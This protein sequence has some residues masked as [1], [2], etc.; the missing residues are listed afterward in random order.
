MNSEG[1]LPL[2]ISEF[3]CV[4]VNTAAVVVLFEQTNRRYTYSWTKGELAL[5]DPAIEGGCDPHPAEIIDCL[6]RA[7]AYQ[8]SRSAPPVAEPPGPPAVVSRT[9]TAQL[10]SFL[11]G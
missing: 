9:L 7:V 4:A 8:A 11:R 6:A 10:A 1:E 5:S 2:D 3:R